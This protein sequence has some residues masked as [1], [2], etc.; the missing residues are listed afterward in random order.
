MILAGAAEPL[1]AEKLEILKSSRGFLRDLGDGKEILCPACGQSTKVDSFRDHVS[2]EEKRLQGLMEAHAA[3]RGAIADLSGAVRSLKAALHRSELGLWR[4]RMGDAVTEALKCIDSV[5]VEILHDASADAVLRNIESALLPIV[6]AAS[7]SAGEA[8]EDLKQLAADKQLSDTGKIVIEAGKLSVV[9]D[10][11]RTLISF[12]N[13]L[14]GGIRE[15]I[16][17]RSQGMV[18]E[19]SSS[20]QVMWSI[21]HPGEPIEEVRLYLP[22]EA[23]KAI[24]IELK[25]HG[26]EQNSPRLTL[27]EGYRNS[28]GL[29]IFLAMASRDPEKDRPLFLDDVV[30]SLDRSHRGMIVELLERHFTDR[31]VVLLSH[32]RDWCAELRQQLQGS[33]WRFQVLMPYENPELGIRWSARASTFDDAM[34]LAKT[35]PHA[36]GNTARKIMDVELAIRAEGMKV[37]MPYL[38]REKND[39]RSAHDFLSRIISSSEKCLRRKSADKYV[40]FPEA[41]AAFRDADKLLVTWGN[42]ASHSFD[43]TSSEAEKLI[44]TLETALKALICQECGKPIHKLEDK[45]AEL[46][47]CQ[48]GRLR[49]QYGKS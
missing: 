49:W 39:H 24:D 31:Q 26:V 42:K 20:I 13:S 11:A 22:G 33:N 6:E 41:V 36:A 21:L 35:M 27:S 38:Y 19:M 15:E 8:P 10:R 29:C 30:V 3:H 18:A 32:D 12:M 34:A 5:N 25:F 2:S 16:K 23:D 40:P 48:C 1:I 28:L 14:E 37:G 17:E 46:V 9:A 43:V 47:Q 44:G 45:S 7:A 4:E